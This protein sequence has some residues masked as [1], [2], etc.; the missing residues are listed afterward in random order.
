M[1]K[2]LTDKWDPELIDLDFEFDLKQERQAT[3][4]LLQFDYNL[5]LYNYGLEHLQ[6]IDY[7]ATT[8]QFSDIQLETSASVDG[9]IL[10]DG[11]TIAFTDDS[12]ANE[13]IEWDS[14]P[15]DAG[16]PGYTTVQ[17]SADNRTVTNNYYAGGSSPRF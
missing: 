3:R 4:P 6:N 2:V 8:E 17:R 1:C 14:T 9:H 5:E 7:M 13:F 11:D 10:E 15:F 12:N 16:A